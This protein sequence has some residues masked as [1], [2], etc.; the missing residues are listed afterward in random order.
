MFLISATVEGSALLGPYQY[1]SLDIDCL[2][3]PME[4]SVFADR[5]IL[6]AL[7]LLSFFLIKHSLHLWVH[8]VEQLFVGSVVDVF[9]DDESIESSSPFHVL[10]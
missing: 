1:L 2:R 10:V 6:P 5:H 3:E 8:D 9:F 7:F 4:R